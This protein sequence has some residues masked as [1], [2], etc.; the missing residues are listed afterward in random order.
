MLILKPDKSN[1][2]VTINENECYNKMNY[3]LQDQSAY[4]L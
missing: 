4:E 2:T 3:L 1:K